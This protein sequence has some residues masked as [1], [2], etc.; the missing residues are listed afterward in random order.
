[1]TTIHNNEDRSA[2]EIL[3]DCPKSQIEGLSV[4]Q[5]YKTT[6]IREVKDTF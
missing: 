6:R 3:H 5:V 2:G 4:Q 1:M